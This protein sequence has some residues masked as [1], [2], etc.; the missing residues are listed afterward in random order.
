MPNIERDVTLLVNGSKA[1][2]SEQIFIFKGDRDIQLNILIA[3]QK[4]KYDRDLASL[5]NVLTPLPGECYAR[6]G[7]LKPNGEI[8]ARDRVPIIDDI[9]Q[10]VIDA[11]ICD[12]L[13]EIG[14]HKIQIQIYAIDDDSSPRWTLPSAAELEI[15]KP[16]VDF[17]ALLSVTNLGGADLATLNQIGDSSITTFN[18]DGTYN[19]TF[20]GKGNV[21]TVN[22]LNKIED[23]LRI[24]TNRVIDLENG[25][26]SDA[27]VVLYLDDTFGK[28]LGSG[29]LIVDTTDFAKKSDV[30]VASDSAVTNMLKSI[31]GS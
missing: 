28:V 27:E 5:D 12:E 31:F 18:D 10:F 23:A 16:D 2:F 8:V 9:V 6:V 29:E 13:D 7:I 14:K 11:D 20:W 25:V 24:L 26:V 3:E 17:D 30:T 22:N 15:L 19:V 4:M 21:I 1:K